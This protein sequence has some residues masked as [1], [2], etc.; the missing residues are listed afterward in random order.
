V[1]GGFCP[2][3][4]AGGGL[5]VVVRL[6]SC[7]CRLGREGERRP[8]EGHGRLVLGHKAGAS[9]REREADGS[10]VARWR[11]EGLESVDDE[12]NGVLGWGFSRLRGWNGSARSLF[13]G[14]ERVV[15]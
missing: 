15:L 7:S 13:R 3:W 10:A 11:R 9:G 4:A 14:D 12:T 6:G 2:S 5:V 8:V 1:V